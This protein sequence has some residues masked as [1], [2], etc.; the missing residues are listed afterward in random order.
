MQKQIY[1]NRLKAGSVVS[2]T[3]EV[4]KEDFDKFVHLISEELINKGYKFIGIMPNGKV[5]VERVIS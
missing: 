1:L 3:L 4:R 5:I 2:V